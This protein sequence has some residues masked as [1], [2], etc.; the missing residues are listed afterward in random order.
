MHRCAP[1]SE[2]RDY[3][4]RWTKEA[5]ECLQ[6]ATESYL[7]DLMA[8]GAICAYHAKRQTLYIVDI[9]LGR[10]AAVIQSSGIMLLR[11]A[12]RRIRGINEGKY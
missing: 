8:D 11:A 10:S 7:T 1:Q 9:R 4:Y 12:V 2:L 5:L 3:P 6:Q